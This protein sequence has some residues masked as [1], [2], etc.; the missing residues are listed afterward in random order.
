MHP[1][2]KSLH[3]LSS[4][5]GYGPGSDSLRMRVSNH[6]AYCDV[7]HVRRRAITDPPPWR[8]DKLA[9]PIVDSRTRTVHPHA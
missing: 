4:W 6:S 8:H 5:S 2:W 1:R 9:V 3:P 7:G